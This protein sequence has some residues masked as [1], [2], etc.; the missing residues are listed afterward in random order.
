MIRKL[1]KD[2]LAACQRQSSELTPVE[3]LLKWSVADPRRRTISPFSQLKVPEWIENR[4]T[5][6]TLNGLR[7]AVQLDPANAR[8]LAHF[9]LALAKLA[10]AEKTDPDDA[11]RARAEA[12]YQTHRA[13]K[14]D[15]D[16]DEVRKLRM[17]V[18]KLLN[19]PSV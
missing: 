6:G 18:V 2:A 3:R 14:L 17:E 5:E 1:P 16:N 12:D 9:G 13:L 4:A 8:L 19:P 10:I 11:R 7:T 15:S